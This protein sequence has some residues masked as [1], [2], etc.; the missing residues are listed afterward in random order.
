MTL[1]LAIGAG[2]AA[3]LA[4]PPAALVA[5]TSSEERNAMFARYLG[6][7]ALVQGGSVDAHWLE[8][9]ERFWYAEGEPDDRRIL[10]VDAEANSAEPFFDVQKLRSALAQTLGHEPPYRGV[11][12]DDFAMAD[13]DTVELQLDD[14]WLRLDLD[15]LQ[16]GPAE[17][18]PGLS[19]KNAS[20]RVS[21]GP[22]SP[23]PTAI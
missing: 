10:L 22:D 1:R 15:Y 11:P 5:Q 14:R 6:F 16:G 23:T 2:L 13:S 19:S 20:L 8:G 7:A 18:G 9:G 21:P 17:C 3:L 4:L 12:F